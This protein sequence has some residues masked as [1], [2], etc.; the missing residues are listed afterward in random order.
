M[1]APNRQLTPA[2]RDKEAVMHVVI[3][4]Y[5]IEPEAIEAV[6]HRIRE[7]FAPYI[8]NVMPGFVEY[9]W[10]NLGNG[11]LMSFSIFEDQAVAEASTKI[12][13]TYVKEHLSTQIRNSPEVIEGEVIVRVVGHT[14]QTST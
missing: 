12:A 13:A 6:N 9:Y 8:S 7:G 3:R 5:K 11:S 2:E 1:V 10:V 14:G 4:H